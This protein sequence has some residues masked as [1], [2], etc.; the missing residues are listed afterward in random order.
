MASTMCTARSN[1]SNN[2]CVLK[3]NSKISGNCI[4]SVSNQE[5]ANSGTYKDI[6]NHKCH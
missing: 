4:S 1:G 3:S 6:T 5:P 2:G